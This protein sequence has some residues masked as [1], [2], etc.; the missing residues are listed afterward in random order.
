MLEYCLLLPNNSVSAPRYNVV[1]QVFLMM[2]HTSSDQR[3]AGFTTWQDTQ[4][5]RVIV[6][7][8]WSHLKLECPV[9]T[10]LRLGWGAR[11]SKPTE[12]AASVSSSILVKLRSRGSPQCFSCYRPDPQFTMGQIQI[13][14]S[15]LEE[16]ST[17]MVMVT[18]MCR[19]TSVPVLMWSSELGFFVVLWAGARRA[20]WP[21]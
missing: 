7:R 18:C 10:T 2:T 11:N 4:H 15:Q 19:V 1:A 20:F 5:H 3:C 16:R 6:T 12:S 13:S 9:K 14:G 17:M 8:P 21:Q